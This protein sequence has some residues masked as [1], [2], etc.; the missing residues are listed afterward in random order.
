VE[1]ITI[2]LAVKPKSSFVENVIGEIFIAGQF[3]QTNHA[4]SIIKPLIENTKLP[5]KAG[6]AMP[7]A[8]ASIENVKK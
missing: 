8:N 4:Q 2:V 3:A 5:Q 6:A 1:D 7:F